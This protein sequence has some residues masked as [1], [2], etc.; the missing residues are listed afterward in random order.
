MV[1]DEGS[2]VW[3]IYAFIPSKAGLTKEM[4]VH[5]GGLSKKRY[6]L[7]LYYYVIWA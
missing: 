5:K 7:L 2:L 6:V 3:D 1:T 4:V